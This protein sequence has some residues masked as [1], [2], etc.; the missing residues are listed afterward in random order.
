MSNFIDIYI[1]ERDKPVPSFCEVC[2]STLQSLEDTECAYKNGSCEN[3]FIMFIRPNLT[4]NGENW[5]PDE[6][7]IKDWLSRKDMRFVPMYKF[8]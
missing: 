7:E 5:K 8:F 1:E 3:C 6:N 2:N 4:L